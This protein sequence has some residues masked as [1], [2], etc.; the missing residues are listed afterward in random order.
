[1]SGTNAGDLFANSTVL[2][3]EQNGIVDFAANG[4]SIGAIEGSGILAIGAVAAAGDSFVNFNR[5]GNFEFSGIITGSGGNGLSMR[6][7]GGTQ[8]LSGTSTFT[9]GVDVQAG[10]LIVKGDVLPNLDGPLGNSIEPII[11]GAPANGANNAQFLVGSASEVGRAIT[12]RASTGA[13]TVTIGGSTDHTS[14]FSGDIALEKRA[15]LTSQTTG[16]N[17]VRIT[18]A[19]VFAIAEHG[20]TK[21]GPG[22]VE[23]ASTANSYTGTTFI[24]QG[25]LRVTG[26]IATSNQVTVNT[27][28]VLDIAAT[29]TIPRLTVESGGK[30]L[31]SDDALGTARVPTIRT[32]TL[33]GGTAAGAF[34]IGKN[35]LIIDYDPGNSPLAQ[36]RA[37]LETGLG[38]THG[39]YTSQTT[40]SARLGIGYVEAS[41]I[42]ATSW[43]GEPVFDDS[44]LLLR[45]AVRGDSDFDDEVSFF[46][47]L[48][49]SANFGKTGMDWTDG[50]FDY[51]GTIA[52]SDLLIVSANYGAKLPVAADLP[53]LTAE[54]QAALQAAMAAVPE[55]GGLAVLGLGAAA[56]LRR[57]R[58]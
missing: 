8:T 16:T 40:N 12:I 3:I 24:N 58:R 17:A 5:A 7:N 36:V 15:F 6:A 32:L 26:S 52:F 20:I 43:L 34:D 38:L 29:Q 18:G 50:D 11:V 2:T 4:D 57:R 51:D 33:N 22:V 42:S 35:G 37:A 47:L 44:A 9:S 21:T 1:M 30:A 10:T 49:V 45:Y 31:V 28:G 25:T 53:G 14:I 56:M 27:G 46:D 23:L 41:E 39:L 54:Q 55:P 48:K 19:L 13:G